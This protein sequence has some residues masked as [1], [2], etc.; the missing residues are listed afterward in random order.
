MTGPLLLL[1]PTDRM[2]E[3][4]RR[5]GE[6]VAQVP[7][8]LRPGVEPV[9][10]PDEADK[11]QRLAAGA[12][13]VWFWPGQELH[14]PEHAMLED[15]ARRHI[16]TLVSPPPATA[17]ATAPGP[18]LDGTAHFGWSDA[19]W[20]LQ[21]DPDAPAEL[22]AGLLAG[23][24]V[25]V[26]SIAELTQDNRLLRA[27]REAVDQ[28]VRT[29]DE[30]LRLAAQLQRDLLPSTLPQLDSAGVDVLFRPAGYVSGDFYHACRLDEH[31]VGFFLADA[32]GHGVPAALMTVLIKQALRLKTIDPSHPDGY[33]L[34]DPH[35]VLARCNRE[36]LKHQQ[37]SARFATAC[38]G[39]LDTRT[40][41]GRLARAGHPYPLVLR[42]DGRR[43]RIDP[44]GSLLGIFEDEQFEVA[45]FQLGPGDRLV[46]FSDGI[47]L[48]FPDLDEQHRNTTADPLPGATRHERQLHALAQGPAD[49]ALKTF[50]DR[51]D[52]QS[53]SLN[54]RDDL[55]I[56]CV[57]YH[58]PA[59]PQPQAHHVPEPDAAKALPALAA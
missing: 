19:A 54:R 50:A 56:L 29:L 13:A 37:G 16:A 49:Q 57:S 40:G 59:D 21:V 58:G 15:L 41:I 9:A 36:M 42:P 5:S 20:T 3:A 8:M 47:E 55:T 1:A 34:A 14:K 31:H 12:S 51:L 53:G 23:L 26:D 39:I 2:P 45:P 22:A 30:E 24:L 48:A 46:L 27:H 17:T 28:Q 43:D 52:A 7:Q 18:D 32:V 6:A 4:L 38:Y 44:E 25:R 11:L 10:W 35:D 33:Q